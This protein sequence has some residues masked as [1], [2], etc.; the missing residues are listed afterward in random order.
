MVFLVA[1][2]IGGIS[3]GILE[4]FSKKEGELA[5]SA[6]RKRVVAVDAKPGKVDQCLERCGNHRMKDWK[7]HAMEWVDWQSGC[8]PKHIKYA[9]TSLGSLLYL[10]YVVWRHNYANTIRGPIIFALGVVYIFAVAR[11]L[12]SVVFRNTKWIVGRHFR[13]TVMLSSAA[14]VC[15]LMLFLFPDTLEWDQMIKQCDELEGFV[16]M[17]MTWAQC[18]EHCVKDHFLTARVQGTCVKF[19]NATQ[20]SVVYEYPGAV[21]TF[22]T[23]TT[24][25]TL[26]A[27]GVPVWRLNS[28]DRNIYS[29]HFN[30]SNTMDRLLVV[31]VVAW[32]LQ[33]CMITVIWAG[34]SFDGCLKNASRDSIIFCLRATVLIVPMALI[35]NEIKWLITGQKGLYNGSEWLGYE[36]HFS[37]VKTQRFLQTFRLLAI[38][39]CIVAVIPLELWENDCS[40]LN[41][42]VQVGCGL[43]IVTL[44]LIHP[45]RVPLPSGPA[46]FQQENN[47]EQPGRDPA[48]GDAAVIRGQAALLGGVHV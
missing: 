5:T 32:L 15:Q 17:P 45:A 42:V 18:P 31:N 26:L 16:G 30:S 28:Q 47:L 3:S 19:Q 34:P 9:L 21:S 23:I 41:K 12:A 46:A 43:C 36:Q 1:M 25:A 8:T 13:L 24:V 38:I 2:T 37:A 35:Q 11:S 6:S 27:N 29:R 20:T 22:S 44:V 10:A 4:C 7:K 40:A 33:V 39:L 48:S 14:S